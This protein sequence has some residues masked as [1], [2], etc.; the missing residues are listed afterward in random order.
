MFFRVANVDMNRYLDYYGE[1]TICGPAV[2]QAIVDARDRGLDLP[3]KSLSRFL[4][5]G[6]V[7]VHRWGSI[8][9]G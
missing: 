5:K 1:D 8:R 6:P 4:C 7:G 2:S 9:S 3:R